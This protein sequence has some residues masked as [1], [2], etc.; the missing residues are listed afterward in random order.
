MMRDRTEEYAKWR[1]LVSEQIESGQSVAAFCRD[2]GLRDWQLYEWKK[3]LREAKAGS[4]VAVKLAAS[5]VR[6]VD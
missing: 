3:R 4:F 2:R 6:H 1:G 5:V